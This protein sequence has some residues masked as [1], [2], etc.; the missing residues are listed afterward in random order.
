LIADSATFALKAGLWVRLVSFVM[1]APDPRQH[2]RR[3]A[4]N[5]P[6]GLSEFPRSPLSSGSAR[7]GDTGRAFERAGGFSTSSQDWSASL[8]GA[9]RPIQ[10]SATATIGLTDAQRRLRNLG[11]YRGAL[12]GLMGPGTRNAIRTF[13]RDRGLPE[14]GELSGRTADAL[15]AIP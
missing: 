8:A 14:T 12:D 3:Q 4:G 13:E 1:F 10:P 9:A 6:I 2:C 15:L 7:T 11:H 5:P